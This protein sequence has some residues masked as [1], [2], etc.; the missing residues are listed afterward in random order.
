MKGGVLPKPLLGLCDGAA[1]VDGA[2]TLW[3]IFDFERDGIALAKF[4]EHDVDE[5][6][7]V[8]KH[9]F[10]LSF[11]GDE[12]ETAVGEGLDDTIH[13]LYGCSA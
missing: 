6:I 11:W 10:A 12:A 13:R 8:K 3:G 4:I 7:R 1:D 9:V 2:R 5:S